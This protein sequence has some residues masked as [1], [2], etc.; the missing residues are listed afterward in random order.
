MD[1]MLDLCCFVVLFGS[2]ISCVRRQI[3]FTFFPPTKEMK[4]LTNVFSDILLYWLREKS[5]LCFECHAICICMTVI[6]V[7]IFDALFSLI[8]NI[9]FFC[10]YIL[11]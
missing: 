11:I 9:L 5:K 3:H 8:C 6:H 1:R 10:I 4:K 7:C 2:P